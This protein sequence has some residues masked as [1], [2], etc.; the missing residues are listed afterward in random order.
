M[1]VIRIIGTSQAVLWTVLLSL[2]GA[3]AQFILR[4]YRQVGQLQQRVD[5]NNQGLQSK[6]A[7]FESE[8]QHVRSRLDSS[9]Q[10]KTPLMSW[11][12]QPA[13]VNLNRRGQV[14]RL[15]RRGDSISE[16]ASGLRLSQ[17]EVKLIVKVHELSRTGVH[18]EG[19][20]KTA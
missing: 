16:I 14:L 15:Y 6:T 11:I 18:P 2:A 13:S 19:R 20:A 5:E 8:I 9:H 3:A 10:N 12:T 17:G 4:L 7:A 1:N